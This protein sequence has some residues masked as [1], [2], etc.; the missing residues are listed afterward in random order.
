VELGTSVNQLFQWF[1]I[2]FSDAA[3]VTPTQAAS[4]EQM[5]FDGKRCFTAA[6]P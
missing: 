5:F 6:L 3:A 2:S 1:C 4:E